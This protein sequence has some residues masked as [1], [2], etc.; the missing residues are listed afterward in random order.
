MRAP[1]VAIA[2]VAVLAV[3]GIVWAELSLH[4]DRRHEDVDA[5]ARRRRMGRHW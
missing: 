2:V 1:A 4:R 3:I 5:L